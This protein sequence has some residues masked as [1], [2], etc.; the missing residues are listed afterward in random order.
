[1]KNFKIPFLGIMSLVL[2]ASC[3]K[4]EDD[5]GVLKLEST[6]D[7]KILRETSILF[8]KLI[9][10][11]EVKKDVLS[12]MKQIEQDGDM[13]SFA[14]LLDEKEKLKKDEIKVFNF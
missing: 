11:N 4:S 6:E 13:V 7:Q 1:M 8:G 9:S 5:I 3:T 2:I 14:F 12:K 10:N